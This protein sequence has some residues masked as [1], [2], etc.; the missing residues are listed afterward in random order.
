MPRRL[1]FYQHKGER[2]RIPK[3]L[4]VSINTDGIQLPNY[5][6][7]VPLEKVALSSH[8]RLSQLYDDIISNCQQLPTN[9]TVAMQTGDAQEIICQKGLLVLRISISMK[10]S[11]EY[12]KLTI[13]NN[14]CI[15]LSEIPPVIYSLDALVTLLSIVDGAHLCVGNP[16]PS[17]LAL[18]RKGKF[19][20]Q[21]GK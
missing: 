6:V 10:W 9:W 2:R 5:I 4:I 8:H 15:L 11:L 20:D 17:Y 1:R 21:P 12:Q 3:K 13:D 19:L 18:S 16:D 14:S 7:S